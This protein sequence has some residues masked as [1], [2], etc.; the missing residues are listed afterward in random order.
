MNDSLPPDTVEKLTNV[1]LLA[2]KTITD[3]DERESEHKKAKNVRYELQV[4]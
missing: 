4:K 3:L 2:E 1:E